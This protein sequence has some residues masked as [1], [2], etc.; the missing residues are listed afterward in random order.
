M[1]KPKPFVPSENKQNYRLDL[2]G[3]FKD[4]L[5]LYESF[6]DRLNH[7]AKTHKQI[8]LNQINQVETRLKSLKK[9]AESL[10]DSIIFH[11]EE[12]IVNR[13]KIIR[14]TE[15]NIHN[16]NESMIHYDRL[17]T[18]EITLAVDYLSKALVSIR[19]DFFDY[20][21]HAYLNSIVATESYFTLF[22]EHNQAFND[23][24]IEHQ[25]AIYQ[26]FSEL[27]DEINYMDESISKL[28]KD[29]N[30]KILEING[31]YEQE[32]K[33]FSDNQLSYSAESD[34]TSIEIQALT[35]D[36]INQFNTFKDHVLL[37]S[38]QIKEQLENEYKS[39][40]SH[41]FSRLLRS[42]SY[43]L[44]K[45]Y[46]FFDDPQPF[47]AAL[48]EQ[49]LEV[50]KTK[51]KRLISDHLDRIKQLENY[52]QL[53]KQIEAKA[54]RLLKPR[55]KEKINLIVFNEKETTKR[56]AKMEL[57]LEQYL[58]VIKHDP[59]LAQ[60]LGDESS[61]LVKDERMY[62]SLLKVNKEL[63]VN[64]NYD[65][66]TTKIK[67]DINQLETNLRYSIRKGI[68]Q[69]E[70]E[71]LNQIFSLND[72]IIEK[73]VQHQLDK[74]SIIKERSVIERFD[75]AANEHLAYLIESLNTNR[76]WLSLVSQVIVDDI[77]SKESHEIYVAE[78]KSQIDYVLKQY[79]MKA[80]HFKTLYEN[81]LSYLVS[82]QS[83]VENETAIDR[84]FVLTTYQNQMRFANEQIEL[85]DHEYRLRL[86]AI[87]E[88]IDD[89][90][91]HY[92]DIIDVIAHQYDEKIHVVKNAFESEFYSQQ[93][94]LEQGLDDKKQKA[95][96]LRI[97]RATQSRDNQI[98][99]LIENLT[100]DKIVLKAKANLL[101]L[102]Q[103]YQEAIM[104]AQELKEATQTQ[105]SELYNDAKERYDTLKPYLENKM[106]IMDSTFFEMLK[107]SEDRMSFQ[108]KKAETELEEQ[109]E[110]LL[111][112]YLEVYFHVDE[113]LRPSSYQEMLDGIESSREQIQLRYTQRLTTVENAYQTKLIEI[114]RQEESIKKEVELLRSNWQS[115][116]EFTN[117]QL[118]KM[119]D[120]IDM[121]YRTHHQNERAITEKNIQM[122]SDEYKEAVK[123]HKQFIDGSSKEFQKLI[124]SYQSYFKEAKKE[125]QFKRLMHPI[126]KKINRR[127]RLALREIDLRYH[128]Y[129]IKK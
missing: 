58:T 102:D 3:S 43:E 29:K 46:H 22:K 76:M 2:T 65:I 13:S 107:R 62:L 47:I 30:Q 60:T 55:M 123:S 14:S 21:Q 103:Y 35:S 11:D 124:D 67:S 45:E 49:T 121:E 108:M 96:R 122:L 70:I 92:Q 91:R 59:F 114:N 83:R 100:N 101:Q 63:K 38:T 82:Q 110:A 93:R 127:L 5:A 80:L 81:E 50:R 20:Y 106:G 54:H 94:Q 34:P 120:S 37:Q 1:D 10:Q 95:I 71:L 79:E 74:L 7:Y 4:E 116:K 87:Q 69:Q 73:S 128:H 36:K 8:T 66:Q 118:K 39:L 12:V 90:R 99:M 117:V 84:E 126:H 24:L 32:I 125:I 23:I 68:Y 88:T 109:T 48:K 78:A 97:D 119:I 16:Q 31:F 77:R 57:A 18:D 25:Q 129:R 44:V 28:M 64:I 98:N 86:E 72:S 61:R 104:D 112:R 56:I 6:F 19:K 40:F 111:H 15:R 42:K 33:Y 53:S 26:R 41:I 17:T 89:E 113:E 75:K 85:A 115:R 52:E 27:D 105:F 9:Q 51:N